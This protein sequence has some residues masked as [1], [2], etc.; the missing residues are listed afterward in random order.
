[1]P[2]R[3]QK[4]NNN[5]GIGIDSLSPSSS[6]LPLD[7]NSSPTSSTSTT[8]TDGSGN[9][10]KTASPRRKNNRKRKKRQSKKEDGTK[11]KCMAITKS[12]NRCHYYSSHDVLLDD[13]TIKR[14]CIHH[15]SK[16]S[17]FSPC[18]KSRYKSCK[19]EIY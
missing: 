11:I 4:R 10:V 16:K 13:G 14:G 19:N 3:T 8:S 2:S 1:M 5:N 18:N 17:W 6:P 12:G 9:T 15:N 7:K